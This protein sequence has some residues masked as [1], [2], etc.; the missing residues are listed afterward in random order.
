[1]RSVLN[2]FCFCRLTKS[3]QDLK[4]TV[5]LQFQQVCDLDIAFSQ[6]HVW[7]VLFIF[8]S[9][10]FMHFL[11]FIILIIFWNETLRQRSDCF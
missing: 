8:F 7:L 3:E 9:S 1:M 5:D 6:Q 11:K 10:F 2:A 4:L